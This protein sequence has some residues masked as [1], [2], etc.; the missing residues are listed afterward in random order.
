MFIFGAG[1]LLLLVAGDSAYARLEPIERKM[2]EYLQSKEA[3]NTNF[4]QKCE[5][6]GKYKVYLIDNFDQKLGLVPEFVLT[7]GEVVQAML[8]SGRSDIDV[9][10]YNTSLGRGLAGVFQEIVDGGCADAVVSSIPGSNY[11]YRQVS[12]ILARGVE[13]DSGNILDYRQDL[14]DIL[15]KIAVSGFPSVEW[16]QNVQVNPI[17][18]REDAKKLFFIE[19]LGELNVPVF[20]PY[21]NVDSFHQGEP[22]IV[23]LLS[24]SANARVFSGVDKGGK[25]LPGF[26]DS[27]LSSGDA[28]ASYTMTECPDYYDVKV[29][30]LDI[31]SD[32][33]TD[34][35]FERLGE[36]PY[37]GEQ[38]VVLHSPSL[39][40]EERFAA[41]LNQVQS[42][43]KTA[44][45]EEMVL[46]RGQYIQLLEQCGECKSLK[47]PHERKEIVWLNSPRNG[48]RA[49]W[50]S[51]QCESRG[52]IRGTSLI[53][54][55]KAKES[56]MEKR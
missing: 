54:P 51:P 14:L 22:R 47:P 33:H 24:L 3:E 38:G 10:V 37:F 49:H 20:L 26:P 6:N 32:G 18:L 7:H 4:Q 56:L 53:P 5:N 21:G 15:M 36:I 42:G 28:L 25:R 34:F 41:V 23:N 45:S 29:T 40:N 48:G 8:L 50:F 52:N 46:T 55:V 27:P 17:K 11:T 35:T 43:Q 39:L 1:V 9:D 19:A 2:I 30:H 13:L 12:S 16:L 31:D 44:I